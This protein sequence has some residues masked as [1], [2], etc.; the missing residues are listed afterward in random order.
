MGTFLSSAER[1]VPVDPFYFKWPAELEKPSPRVTV[2][3][4]G[5][6]ARRSALV[7]S[8]YFDEDP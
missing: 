1:I 6:P 3:L 7:F 5:Y 2:V 8:E 4:P